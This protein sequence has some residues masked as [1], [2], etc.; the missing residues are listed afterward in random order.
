MKQEKS[1]FAFDIEMPVLQQRVRLKK[2]FQ[3]FLRRTI[4]FLS[5]DLH[6][7]SRI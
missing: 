3:R 1:R 2:G 7:L 4:N 6:N 5:T